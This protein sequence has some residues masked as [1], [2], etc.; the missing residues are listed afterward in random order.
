MIYIGFSKH[1]NKIYAK[2]FCR[3]FKHC[4][5]VME[6]H[7]KFILF[8]F[9][10]HNDIHKIYLKKRDI[11]ILEKHGWKFVKYNKKNNKNYAMYSKSFTCVQFTKKFCGIHDIK[12][13]TP[14]KLIEYLQQ[15]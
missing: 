1:S 4:A 2:I 9:T 8:Q 5:P 3:C 13:Q 14:D 10:K 15:K 11:K 7:D 6:H 12:I